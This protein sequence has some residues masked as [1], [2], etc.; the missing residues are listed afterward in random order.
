MTTLAPIPEQLTIPDRAITHHYPYFRGTEL[1]D[2]TAL[3]T[4]APERLFVYAR[5]ATHDKD[6]EVAAGEPLLVGRAN[7]DSVTARR[8]DGSSIV[9]DSQL[10]TTTRPATVV[11]P[12]AP[13]VPDASSLENATAMAAPEDDKVLAAYR[14]QHDR[15]IR[16]YQDYVEKN[17][18]TIGHDAELYRVSG[19]RITNVSDEISK[20]ADRRCGEARD[21]AALTK[22]LAALAKTRAARWAKHL[23]AVRARFGL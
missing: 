20:A 21:G 9:I 4:T 1:S 10:I 13:D 3:F 15:F 19:N 12:T 14:A 23:A 22:T 17:D 5:A 7:D 6:N 18:P 8:Y 16:C 11:L 2:W